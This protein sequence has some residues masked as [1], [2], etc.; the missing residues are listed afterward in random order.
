MRSN[1]SAKHRA[2]KPQ[3]KRKYNKAV[4]VVC[5]LLEIMIRNLFLSLAAVVAVRVGNSGVVEFSCPSSFPVDTT[6]S[7]SYNPYFPS[8]RNCIPTVKTTAAMIN[9][10]RKA[11]DTLVGQK[12]VPVN[13]GLMMDLTYGG[14]SEILKYYSLFV[15]FACDKP[16]QLAS[17]NLETTELLNLAKANTR[18]WLKFAYVECAIPEA[19]ET[20]DKYQVPINKERKVSLI[21]NSWVFNSFVLDQPAMESFLNAT[22][23]MI[24]SK[25]FVKKISN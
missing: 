6:V 7:L 16:D 8:L 2:L 11:V 9:T 18:P 19:K 1:G 5:D 4:R 20:C 25:T 13:T 24:E 17:T 22:T 3:A 14:M 10:A 12:L 23:K 21:T 15:I